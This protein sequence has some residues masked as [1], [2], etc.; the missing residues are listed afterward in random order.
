[1]LGFNLSLDYRSH[2]NKGWKTRELLRKKKTRRND[3]IEK[4]K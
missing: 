1:M 3:V 2:Q 4:K